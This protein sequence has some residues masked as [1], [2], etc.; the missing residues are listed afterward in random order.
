MQFQQKGYPGA[1]FLTYWI[2]S[3]IEYDPGNWGGNS[4]LMAFKLWKKYPFL[5]HVENGDAYFKYNDSV[6]CVD[7]HTIYL[8]ST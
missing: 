4:V 3:Y 6:S 8:Q 5:V 1:K 7:M 2:K